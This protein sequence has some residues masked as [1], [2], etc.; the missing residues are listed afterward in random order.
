MFTAAINRSSNFIAIRSSSIYIIL[1][2]RSHITMFKFSLVILISLGTIATT[3]LIPQC[4]LATRSRSKKHCFDP[5]PVA[6]RVALTLKADKKTL[7][8]NKI[9]FQPI[10]EKASVKPGDIIKYTVIAKNNS[11]CPLKNLILKQPIPRGTNYRPDSATASDGAELLFSIDGG[12]TFSTQPTI[13][14][15]P[16]PPTAYNYLR[17]KFWGKMEINAQVKTTYE[18]QVK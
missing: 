17:W 14:T 13:G 18:L 16:A 8:D 15:E 1:A 2:A 11:H 12:K 6:Q 9:V 10:A 3:F 4:S 5:L 7:V